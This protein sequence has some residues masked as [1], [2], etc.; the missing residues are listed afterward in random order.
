MS[1]YDGET[2]GFRDAKLKYEIFLYKI[3]T[4][5]DDVTLYCPILFDT[6]FL[7]CIVIIGVHITFNQL[8]I[9]IKTTL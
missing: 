6:F 5:F 7:L 9:G 1:L 4:L 2:P 3:F 8:K